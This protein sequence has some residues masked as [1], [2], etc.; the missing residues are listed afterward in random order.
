MASVTRGD[1]S[2]PVFG[3][4]EDEKMAGREAGLGNIANNFVAARLER[5]MR[6]QKS[7]GWL[8]GDARENMG[9]PRDIADDPSGTWVRPERP[10]RCR[11]RAAA[12]VGVH[13]SE[14]LERA[15]YSGLERCSSI[16]ACPVCSPII[17]HGRSDDIQLAAEAAGDLGLG[18]VFVTMTQRH[19]WGDALSGT[20]D[21]MIKGWGK[22]QGR[23]A[24]RNLSK[25]VGYIGMIRATEITL[26]GNGWHPHN[27]MLMFFEKPLTVQEIEQYQY[28]LGAMWIRLCQSMGGGV[29]TLE[30][31]VKAVGVFGGGKVL[32]EYITKVQEGGGEF[33][34][35]ETTIG[36]EIARGDLKTGRRDSILPFQLLDAA[37]EG[38]ETARTLWLEYVAATKGRRAFAWSRGLRELLLPGVEEKTDEE[39]IE[40]TEQFELARVLDG[41]FYDRHLRDSPVNNAGALEL[42]ELGLADHIEDELGEN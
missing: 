35:R 20:L 25:R 31:G 26:G 38:S 18:V 3:L 37:G 12:S 1:D 14:E 40:D 4:S 5:F 24:W 6:R 27:H 10:A 7:S 34:E 29:P 8:I 30:H 39:I 9:L 13:V 2:A 41:K 42:A 32:A 36:L 23:T 22:L 19:A 15:H 16:W 17:R 11:W 33:L 28:D 21:V